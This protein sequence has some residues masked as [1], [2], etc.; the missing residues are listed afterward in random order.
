ML[1]DLPG[2]NL[3]QRHWFAPARGRDSPPTDRRV[4]RSDACGSERYAPQGVTGRPTPSGV[5]KEG[6]A[7]RQ[8][9]AT[10]DTSDEIGRGCTAASRAPAP[11]DTQ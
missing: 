11:K 5:D 9:I 4:L 1:H 8:H 7:Y 2:L 3:Q 10:A 6:Q